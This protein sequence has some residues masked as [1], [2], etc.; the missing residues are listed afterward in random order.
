[1]CFECNAPQSHAGNEC[2]GLFARIFGAPLPGWTR[3]WKKDA[4][5]WTSYGVAIMLLQPSREA[6]AKYLKDHCVPVHR[7]WPVS[8]AEIAAQQLPELRGPAP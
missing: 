8:T 6:L 2:L 4:A 1:M 3:D 5:A 7:F